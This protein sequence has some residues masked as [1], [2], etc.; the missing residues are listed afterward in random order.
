MKWRDPVQSIVVN[1][2][3]RRECLSVLRGCPKPSKT[4]RQPPD[5]NT[6]RNGL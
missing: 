1:I 5:E 6:E 4:D 2:E 3:L